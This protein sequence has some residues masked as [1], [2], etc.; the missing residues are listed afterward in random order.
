MSGAAEEPQEDMHPLQ[1]MAMAMAESVM[2]AEEEAAAEEMAEA[3][4]ITNPDEASAA[5]GALSGYECKLFLQKLANNPALIAPLYEALAEHMM[6]SARNG[7]PEE[8]APLSVSPQIAAAMRQDALTTATEKKRKATDSIDVAMAACGAVGEDLM[9]ARNLL[10]KITV[11]L[12]LGAAEA[13]KAVHDALVLCTDP[14]AQKAIKRADRDV[15]DVVVLL[16]RAECD[17][18]KDR[19]GFL[20]KIIEAYDGD[21]DKLVRAQLLL[22]YH[23]DPVNQECGF[24]S[25]NQIA[26]D[27]RGHKRN[28][29]PR[30]GEPEEVPDTGGEPEEVPDTGGA[31]GS[32]DANPNADP[33]YV[34]V[35]PVTQ[36]TRALNPYAPAWSPPSSRGSE[37][38]S[39]QH[40]SYR[41]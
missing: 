26:T 16:C 1:A 12:A 30:R 15:R 32:G 21:L 23:K 36:N 28:R 4:R 11:P 9:R 33:M 13:Q 40:V 22:A 5:V 10:Q 17:D 19:E 29:R 25:N 24:V 37:A 35:Q 2:T 7:F 34:H 39:R 31:S 3:Q 8:P 14:E 27:R 38:S 18:P 6:I 20:Q 41:I